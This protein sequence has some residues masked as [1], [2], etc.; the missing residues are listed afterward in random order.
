[1]PAP[2]LLLRSAPAGLRLRRLRRRVRRLCWLH[3]GGGA[4]CSHQTILR[5]APAPAGLRLCS[6]SGQCGGGLS[7]AAPTNAIIGV[8]C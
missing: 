7:S 8:L 2:A 1:M 5:G 6:G 4:A 3:G